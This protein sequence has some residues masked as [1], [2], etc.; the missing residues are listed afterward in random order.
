MSFYA[1]ATGAAATSLGLGTLSSLDLGREFGHYFS[2]VRADTDALRK[3]SYA[4][5]HAVYCEELRYEPLRDDGLERDEHDAHADHLLLASAEHGRYV[6]CAR[7]I[8]GGGYPQPPFPIELLCGATLGARWDNLRHGRRVG[9]LSRLAVVREFRRRKGE[10]A[11]EVAIGEAD[12][13]TASRP[14]FPYIPVGLCLAS[15]ALAVRNGLD[16]IVVLA[17]PQLATHLGR[18]GILLQQVGG[19]VQHHGT[20]VPCLLDLPANVAGM[21]SWIKPLYAAVERDLDRPP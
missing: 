14:R 2:V 20:R 8:H 5:R 13:G 10:E 11:R 12:F 19:P 9:E 3:E 7:L 18:L 17:E 21:R 4:I 1:E 15:V 16:A 6:A